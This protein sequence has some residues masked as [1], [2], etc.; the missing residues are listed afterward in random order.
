MILRMSDDALLDFLQNTQ[1]DYYSRLRPD[2]SA[3]HCWLWEG[4][5]TRG[6]GYFRHKNRLIRATHLSLYLNGDGLSEGRVAMHTC[7][8]P[9]CVNPL[10]LRWATQAENMADMRAKNR[11]SAGAHHSE[12]MR[13]AFK[14]GTY[15][16][17]RRLSDVQVS[18]IRADKRL[19]REIAADYGIASSYV[20]QIK[21]G[22]RRAS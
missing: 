10:H 12:A 21:K 13:R 6:Y 20:C 22:D 18:A 9:N 5:Q 11:A 1:A 15:R 8:T 7:D 17:A 2:L 14:A 19:H 4:A 16:P 3:D